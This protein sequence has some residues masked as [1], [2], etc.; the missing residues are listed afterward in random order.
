MYVIVHV[1]CMQEYDKQQAKLDKQ[2]KKT[3]QAQQPGAQAKLD[4]VC[5]NKH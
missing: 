2:G 1:M 3:T 5:Q 4:L